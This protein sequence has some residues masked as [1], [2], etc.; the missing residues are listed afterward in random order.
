MIRP[1]H[2][3]SL[4]ILGLPGCSASVPEAELPPAV[5][6]LELS[7]ESYPA[8]RSRFRTSLIRPGPASQLDDPLIEP[9]G[10]L[11]GSY[12]SDGLSLRC[13]STPVVNGIKRPALLFLHGGFSIGPGDWEMTAPFRDAGYVVLIP[14]LRGENGQEGASSLFYDEVADVL[15]AAEI[16]ANRPDVDPDRLFV[17]GHSAGG[18]LTLLASL[19]SGRFQAAASFSGSPDMIELTRG[20]LEWA[21]FPIDKIE[22]F[23]VRSAVAFADGFQCPVRLYLGDG[24]LWAQASTGRTVGLARRAG[25]DVEAVMLPGGHDSVT[26]ASVAL[27]LRFFEG[28]PAKRR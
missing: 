12:D 14:T 24:E 13:Y 15:A 1:I 5:P 28:V 25:R 16:L 22:E 2:L 27:C 21:P 11:V 26:P 17:A 4:L 8:L 10:A 20:R 23:R 7:S 19:A 9:P 18:T 3:A 6:G